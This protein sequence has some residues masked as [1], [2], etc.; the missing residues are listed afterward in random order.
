MNTQSIVEFE[1]GTGDVLAKVTTDNIANNIAIYEFQKE[2]R[3]YVAVHPGTVLHLDLSQVR[4]FSCTVLSDLLQI[5]RELRQTNGSLRLQGIHGNVR[6][7]MKLTGL[8]KKFTVEHR[9]EC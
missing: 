2:L 7:I 1:L 9:H 3:E 5:Q 8:G 6:S 4:L